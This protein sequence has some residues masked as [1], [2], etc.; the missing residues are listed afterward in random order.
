[1]ATLPA[2]SITVDY[3]DSNDAMAWHSCAGRSGPQAAVAGKPAVGRQR[4]EVAA[5]EN[6]RPDVG[7]NTPAMC[8][9]GS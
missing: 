4:R 2:P 6:T 1:M 9:P 3:Q 7:L 8:Q 5:L